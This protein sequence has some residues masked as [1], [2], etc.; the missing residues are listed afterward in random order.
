[1]VDVANETSTEKGI[2]LKNYQQ[3]NP[4][5]T[6][7]YLE[8][9]FVVDS[10]LFDMQFRDIPIPPQQKYLDSLKDHVK[11][12][13]LNLYGAYS[14]DPEQYVAYLRRSGGYK[15]KRGYQGFQF[16]YQNVR[17]VTDFLKNFGYIEQDEGYLDLEKGESHLSKMRATAKLIDLIEKHKK[18]T[19]DM[20]KTDTSNE[21]VIIVKGVNQNPNGKKKSKMAKRR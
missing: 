5:I 17:K 16:G 3:M 10:I 6:S 9:G 21:E 8:T 2:R 15:K 13:I 12:I 19:P 14:S 18:V 11:V 1:M 4:K 20:I 7:E